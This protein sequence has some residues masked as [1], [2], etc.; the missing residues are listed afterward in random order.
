MA[1][2]PAR[3]CAWMHRI[4]HTHTH[5]HTH[6]ATDQHQTS[7]TKHQLPSKFC[8][9][10]VHLVRSLSVCVWGGA[11]A[12]RCARALF[13]NSTPASVVSSYGFPIPDVPPPRVPTWTHKSDRGRDQQSQGTA[14]TSQLHD[15]FFYPKCREVK[16]RAIPAWARGGERERESQRERAV[17]TEWSSDVFA[18]CSAGLG[19]WPLLSSPPLSSGWWWHGSEHRPPPQHTHTHTHTRT[20]QHSHTISTLLSVYTFNCAV[21]HFQMLLEDTKMSET[22]RW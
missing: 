10:K 1:P 9:L 5:T 22:H 17:F 8:L 11:R 6:G 7:L 3:Q 13:T 4:C 16:Q 20:T 19:L 15:F 21:W 18:G 14:A 2:V 12:R